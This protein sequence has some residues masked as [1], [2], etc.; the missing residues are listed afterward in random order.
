MVL[1][2]NQIRCFLDVFLPVMPFE[3]CFRQLF[4]CTECPVKLSLIY[5]WKYL[6]SLGREVF[7]SLVTLSL[8]LILSSHMYR[9]YHPSLNFVL[10]FACVK[11]SRI[12]KT[13]INESTGHQ[14]SLLKWK[15]AVQ[16]ETYFMIFYHVE[17]R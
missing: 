14:C 13:A 3:M 2:A 7:L 11:C 6:V 17:A 10:A 4:V 15:L 5:F 1:G 8:V 12:N 9:C 16:G